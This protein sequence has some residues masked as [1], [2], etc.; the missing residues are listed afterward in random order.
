LASSEHGG[1]AGVQLG[2]LPAALILAVSLGLSLR[3]TTSP[4]E[5]YQKG[6]TVY[7]E[8]QLQ[9]RKWTDQSGT[10]KYTSEVVLQGFS[11]NLTV[12]DGRGG[13]GGYA[14][15]AGSDFGAGGPAPATR[16]TVAAGSRDSDMD[17][18][19]PFWCL[20]GRMEGGNTR[21]NQP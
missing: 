18:D 9:T 14:E 13:G 16:R 19:I 7:I 2:I 20:S 1:D 6:A 17:D 21:R 3:L 10:E 15:D 8:G 12:L 11:S 5:Q 4:V